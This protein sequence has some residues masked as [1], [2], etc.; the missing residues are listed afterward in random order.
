MRTEILKLVENEKIIAIVRGIQPEKCVSVAEALYKGGVHMME[1]TFDQSKPDALENTTASIASVIR[2]FGKDIR[3][4]AGTVMS[5]EQ[6]QM[7]AKAGAE[8]IISPNTRESVIRETLRLGLVSMPGALTPTEAAFAHEC[9]A[10]FV[11]IFP[12]GNLGPGYIKALKAP[13]SHIKFLGVG[14]ITPE[15]IPDYLNAGCAG[16]G[17]GGNLVSASWTDV[18]KRQVRSAAKLPSARLCCY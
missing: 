6:V 1:I 4:G 17:I 11:K 7:A 3:V 15:N 5:A 16:F 10:D 2:K 13:L 12:S 18:Y 9:G 14:G 8:Y